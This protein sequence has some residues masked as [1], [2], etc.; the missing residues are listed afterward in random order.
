[1][2]DPRVTELCTWQWTVRSDDELT[3]ASPNDGHPAP[4]VQMRVRV[5]SPLQVRSSPV[6]SAFAERR[7]T[8]QRQTQWEVSKDA[9]TL[10]VRKSQASCYQRFATARLSWGLGHASRGFLQTVCAPAAMAVKR[11]IQKSKARVGMN[12]RPPASQ[13]GFSRPVVISVRNSKTGHDNNPRRRLTPEG[14]QGCAG[15][16]VFEPFPVIASELGKLGTGHSTTRH[17]PSRQA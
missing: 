16:M 15:R 12:L 2:P 17:H 14:A 11:S 13:I 3:F 4:A 6:R 10:I 5:S 8:R 1:M 7:T 9:P